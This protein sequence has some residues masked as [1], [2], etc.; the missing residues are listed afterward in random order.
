MGVWGVDPKFL[1]ENP[2]KQHI[3]WKIFEKDYYWW[4]L[5][6]FI[7]MQ[8]KMAPILSLRYFSLKDIWFEI[9]GLSPTLLWVR[10]R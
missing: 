7:P 3:I 4:K 5:E 10:V 8:K 6:L 1:M 9:Y 2:I